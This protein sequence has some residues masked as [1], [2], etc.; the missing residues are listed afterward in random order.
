MLTLEQI[1]DLLQDRRPAVVAK[2]TGVHVNTVL[3]IRDSDDPNPTY[4]VY[5]ALSNYFDGDKA[6]LSCRAKEL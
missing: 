4:K 1:K 6:K 5:A 2:A 3:S